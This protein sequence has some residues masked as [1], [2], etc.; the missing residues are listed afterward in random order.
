MEDETKRQEY[1]RTRQ[2]LVTKR[3][4]EIMG[5]HQDVGNLSAERIYEMSSMGLM[6][7]DRAR[8]VIH[9]CLRSN[10]TNRAIDEELDEILSKLK[11]YTQPLNKYECKMNSGRVHI[12]KARNAKDAKSIAEINHR[13]RVIS[14]DIV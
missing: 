12:I 10:M 14:V 11:L 8:R 3:Y 7:T 9:E 5:N 2:L 6:S 13:E 1:A 4:L